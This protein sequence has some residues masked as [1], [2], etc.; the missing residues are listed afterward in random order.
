MP[1]VFVPAARRIPALP[2]QRRAMHVD[3]VST[4]T[5][6]RQRKDVFKQHVARV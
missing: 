3:A 1:I 5:A 2:A 4:F 6:M